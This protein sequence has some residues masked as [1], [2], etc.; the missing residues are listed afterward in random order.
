M[1][2]FAAELSNNMS[3]AVIAR[4]STGIAKVCSEIKALVLQCPTSVQ[5]V[6]DFELQ[7]FSNIARIVWGN[8]LIHV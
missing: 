4:A 3:E 7:A 8:M 1:K 2:S 5:D 6:Q